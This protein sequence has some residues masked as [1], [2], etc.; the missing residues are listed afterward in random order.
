[1]R[2]K[3]QYLLLYNT[4]VQELKQIA[5]TLKDKVDDLISKDV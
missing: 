5:A 3:L 1:M 4:S 2:N